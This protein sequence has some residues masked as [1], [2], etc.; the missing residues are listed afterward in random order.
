M[1][2]ID[3]SYDHLFECRKT[4]PWWPW[5]GRQFSV[6]PIKTMV[7]GESIY[8][9]NS[10][11][12]DF[13]R[14]Y[15]Q[16]SGLRVTHENNALQFD[17]NSVYVRNIERAIFFAFKPKD[18]QKLNLWT[19]VVYHNLVLQ[20][21]PSNGHRPSKRHYREG[22]NEVLD[23]C[24]LLKVEQCLVYGLEAAKMEALKLVAAERDLDCVIRRVGTK[25]GRSHP[26]LGTVGKG[27]SQLKFLFVRHPSSFFSWKQWSPVLRDNLSLKFVA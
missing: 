18:E 17:R 3:L 27:S 11:S 5:I 1:S 7:V 2:F 21:L 15:A 6:S 23:L 8:E 4:L 16:T 25:V 26:K 9:W 19:S 12:G 14:R 13:A 22:W 20:A 10:Q 24:D